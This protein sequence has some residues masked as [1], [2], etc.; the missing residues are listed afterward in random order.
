MREI[1]ETATMAST[2]CSYLE[3]YHIVPHGLLFK[4]LPCLIII[5]QYSI[6]KLQEQDVQTSSLFEIRIICFQ[7]FSMVKIGNNT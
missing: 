4:P 1:S 5:I 6:Y 7:L 2:R 3:N